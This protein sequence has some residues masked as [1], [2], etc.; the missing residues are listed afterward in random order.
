MASKRDFYE[1]L[2]VKKGASEAEIKSAYRKLALQWHPDKHKDNKKAAEDK[3]KEINEAYQVLSDPQKKQTY[4]QFGHSAFE[5]GGGGN[6]FSGGGNP[7]A[8]GGFR[9]GP[10]QW[11]YTSS[12]GGNPFE[13]MG[14]GGFGDPFD[15]FEQF[16]GGGMRQQRKP[17]YGLRIDFMEAVKGTEKSVVIQGK[18]KKIKIP[19]GASEGTRI[20]FDEFEVVLEVRPDDRFTRE[21]DDLFIEQKI[22]FVTAALGGEIEVP[23]VNKPI[24]IKVKAGTQPNSLIRLREEGVPHLRGRGNGDLYIR[25]RVEVPEKINGRQRELLKQFENAG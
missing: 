3:F 1:V 18:E 17:R 13:G 8:G 25:L 16:F 6:P 24:K 2:G 15:I 7:F 23:T 9:S 4:D 5:N 19:A 12:S 14:E 21:G 11:S 22:S 10:F 20:Q